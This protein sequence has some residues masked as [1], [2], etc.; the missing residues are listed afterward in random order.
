MSEAFV[1]HEFREVGE[2]RQ[3]RRVEGRMGI[4]GWVWG[5]VGDVSEAELGDVR[6][7][8]GEVVANHAVW[9]GGAEVVGEERPPRHVGVH[10]LHEPV[11]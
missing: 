11:H 6:R 4:A 5:V 8:V 2:G 10:G 3:E 1:K 7:S 9:P